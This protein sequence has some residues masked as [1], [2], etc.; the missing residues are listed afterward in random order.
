ML[1]RVK[2]GDRYAV[3]LNLEQFFDTVNHDVLMSRI[4]RK[5][6]DK[7]LLS[8]IGRYLRAGVLV[9]STIQATDRGWRTFA[10][11]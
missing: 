5:V 4:A 10:V 6:T 11:T 8:L 1:N 9:G 3:D 7:V 2:S